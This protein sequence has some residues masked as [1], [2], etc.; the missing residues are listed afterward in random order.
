MP[1]VCGESLGTCKEL[2]EFQEA[3]SL[4]SLEKLKSMMNFK[5]TFSSN[6]TITLVTEA[7]T[8]GATVMRAQSYFILPPSV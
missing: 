6:L 2:K 8:R 1:Q 5:K 3:P 7:L 4:F